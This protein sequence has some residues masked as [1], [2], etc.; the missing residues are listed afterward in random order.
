[1]Y[2]YTSIFQETPIT[3]ITSVF[4]L[5]FFA[6]PLCCLFKR[7]CVDPIPVQIHP[8]PIPTYWEEEPIPTYWEEEPIPTYGEE[9]TI[10]TYEE[11]KHM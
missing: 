10:P 3:V 1:M 9:D 11:A 2:N 4:V 7:F 8:L 6:I 5:L